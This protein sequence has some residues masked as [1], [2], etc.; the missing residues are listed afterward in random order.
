MDN[1]NKIEAFLSGQMSDVE[2]Q[3]FLKS[4]NS[5]LVLKKEFDFQSEIIEGIKEFRK[6]EIIARL[7]EVKIPTSIWHSA[8]YK[9]MAGIVSV[10][11]ITWGIFTYL[12]SSKPD[13]DTKVV[14]N[15]SI[16]KI[17]PSIE[18]ESVQQKSTSKEVEVEKAEQDATP[19]VQIPKKSQPTR[20]E[21]NTTFSVP[22]IVDDFSEENDLLEEENL[23][24]P[25][26]IDLTNDKSFAELDV[27]VKLTKKYDFHYQMS[28]GKLLLYGDFDEDLFELIEVNAGEQIN[29]FLFYNDIFYSIDTNSS[30]INALIAITSAEVIKKLNSVKDK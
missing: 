21:G 9:T 2:G 24:V 29:L 1:S 8:T 13:T 5:D 14:T 7:N 26:S 10:A 20:N 4:L 27:E 22:N 28:D 16:E 17:E 30:E 6:A 15:Q 11:A 23:G 25:A 19:P 3:Q 12:D 18:K